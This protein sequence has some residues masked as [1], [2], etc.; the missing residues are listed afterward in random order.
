MPAARG[1]DFQVLSNRLVTDW[2]NLPDPFTQQT[3]VWISNLYSGELTFEAQLNSPPTRYTN[4]SGKQ[5]G[6]IAAQ[7]GNQFTLSWNVSNSGQASPINETITL[8]INAYT[9]SNYTGIYT[10][11]S[12]TFNVTFV[13]RD[14]HIK[15]RGEDFNNSGG[16]PLNQVVSGTGLDPNG[17]NNADTVFASIGVIKSGWIR[18]L[19]PPNGTA[20]SYAFTGLSGQIATV[21]WSSVE[22]AQ[23]YVIWMWLNDSIL[24]RFSGYGR[25]MASGN[26]GPNVIYVSSQTSFS[27][28]SGVTILNSQPIHRCWEASGSTTTETVPPTQ[29]SSGAFLSSGNSLRAIIN[30]RIGHAIYIYHD[31]SGNVLSGPYYVTFHVRTPN[32]NSGAFGFLGSK[33]FSSL[34]PLSGDTWYRFTYEFARGEANSSGYVVFQYDVVSGAFL[35]DFYVYS[36]S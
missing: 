27:F 31:F 2:Y 4:Y 8:Q 19:S 16:V 18:E 22:G 5:L 17:F 32:R 26:T 20:A 25:I 28:T 3:Q 15:L 21:S 10:T 13:N 23:N 11:G 1:I 7:N 36:I 29:Y 34:A 9:S 24:G 12:T 6:S 33:W 14:N 35:D 30:G